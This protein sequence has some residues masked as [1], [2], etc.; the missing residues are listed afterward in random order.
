MKKLIVVL[1]VCVFAVAGTV[2]A[3]KSHGTGAGTGKV[4]FQDIHFIMLQNG[5]NHLTSIG[6]VGGS[7][8][9]VK[10]ANN[11]SEVI[12]KDAAGNTTR[13]IPARGVVKGAPKTACKSD[14]FFN[15][16]VKNIGLV[17]CKSDIQDGG[18][19][20]TLDLPDGSTSKAQNRR[21]EVKLTK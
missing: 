10:K 20:I 6:G 3:Q 18:F 17:I 14:M 4:V 5:L 7:V 12:Y 21:V 13:L 2:S 9:F 1:T 19:H 16:N 11:F 8:Q 15:D